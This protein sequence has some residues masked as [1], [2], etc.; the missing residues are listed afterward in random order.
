[1]DSETKYF[2][3]N[4]T[5]DEVRST[6]RQIDFSGRIE[7]LIDKMTD[8][9][10]DDIYNN[11]PLFN[12]YQRQVKRIEGL[13]VGYYD[14][15]YIE[16]LEE[17]D[18]IKPKDH[19]KLVDMLNLK[20]N[21][22]MGLLKRKGF[23]PADDTR[24]TSWIIVRDILNRIR[25]ELD[26]QIIVHGER[27]YGKSTLA[28]ELATEI[29][30][31]MKLTFDVTKH[32]FFN[33]DDMRTYIYKNKPAP[34]QP[35]IW[36]EAGAGKGMGKRRA[37]TRESIEFNEVIQLIREMGLVI[38]Y[39]APAESNL[40]SGTISM[41]SSEI[42]ALRIDRVEKINIVKYKY[43]EGTYF[44]YI[45][46]PLGNRITRITI[47]KPHED[48]IKTYKKMKKNIMHMKVEVKADEKKIKK[49]ANL[50]EIKKYVLDNIG[51]YEKMS[52]GRRIIDDTKMY[53]HFKKKFL[54]SREAK[55]IKGEIEDEWNG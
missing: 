27:G 14:E 33:P 42:E 17:I 19:K 55:Y 44:K 48:I 21:A 13:L 9:I 52:C 22:C 37:M 30:E 49:S 28:I 24:N 45:T 47:P 34:G 18:K 7:N 39:T 1:M 26:A 25:S 20:F 23:T 36:D 41:F 32:V 43:R 2:N 50:D 5:T 31:A 16:Q 29:A 54:T 4:Y 51:E 46:D 8:T 40:D 12:A 35:L 3:K 38:F 6:G 10:T 15:Y 53:I 11:I